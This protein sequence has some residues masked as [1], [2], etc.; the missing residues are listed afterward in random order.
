MRQNR[1]PD[2]EG[3]KTSGFG[4]VPSKTMGQNR[5]PD[6]EGI[7]TYRFDEIF[8]IV[9]QNRRPDEEGI[10]TAHVGAVGQAV[11]SEP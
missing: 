1:R 5:R 10:K 9:C 2:E 3:I 4:V 7:K 11:E 8:H 6:E